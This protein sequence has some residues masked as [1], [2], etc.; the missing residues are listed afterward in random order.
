MQISQKENPRFKLVKP[1]MVVT[2]IVA[3]IVIVLA[4]TAVPRYIAAIRSARESVLAE[5]LHALRDGV[6]RY[7]TDRKKPPQSL[8][9]LLAS[10]YIKQI[11]EDPMT[12]SKETWVAHT[13]ADLH[14]AGIDDVHSGSRELGSNG[15]PYSS[16]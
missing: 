10:G 4:V 8:E 5:D 15:H 13:I 3:A 11:P 1:M 9:D 12:H 7:T 14:Y 6:H 16:W 2:A